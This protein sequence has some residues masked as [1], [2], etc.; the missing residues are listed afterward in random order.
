MS[1]K[2]GD[3]CLS[4]EEVWKEAVQ[5]VSPMTPPSPLVLSTVID[6]DGTGDIVSGK[7]GVFWDAEIGMVG[8]C[9]DVSYRTIQATETSEGCKKIEK[10]IN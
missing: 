6:K 2:W 1:G 4:V 5:A 10:E 3:A 7:P 9:K 8:K